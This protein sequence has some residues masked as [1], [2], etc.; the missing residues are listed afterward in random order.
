MRLLPLLQAQLDQTADAL[1]NFSSESDQTHDSCSYCHKQRHHRNSI[2]PL[3]LPS[4]F[5]SR[6]CCP[7]G[8]FG[9]A[10]RCGRGARG[11]GRLFGLEGSSGPLSFALNR[12]FLSEHP[13]LCDV[14]C[15]AH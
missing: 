10:I 8:S 7:L 4:L 9:G 3:G 14:A 1:T 2:G 5:F 11:S 15:R 13:T 6:S 12:L